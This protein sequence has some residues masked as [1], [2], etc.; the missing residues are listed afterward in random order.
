MTLL[1][2]TRFA[3]TSDG[4]KP[5]WLNFGDSLRNKLYR[6]LFFISIANLNSQFSLARPF[7]FTFIEGFQ[8]SDKVLSLQYSDGPVDCPCRQLAGGACALLWLL[9]T[10]DADSERRCSDLHT[11]HLAE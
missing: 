10:T 8:I 1:L 6:K 7:D 9:V 3:A 11:M 4:Q 2:S 5:I